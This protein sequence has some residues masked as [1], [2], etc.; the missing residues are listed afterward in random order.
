MKNEDMKA[1]GL[2]LHSCSTCTPCKET[3]NLK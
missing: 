1:A 3:Y 2:I